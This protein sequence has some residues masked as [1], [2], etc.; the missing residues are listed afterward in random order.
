M[1]AMGQKQ[2]SLIKS[3]LELRKEYLS[4]QKD[5]ERVSLIGEE[6]MSP[7]LRV[8]NKWRNANLLFRVL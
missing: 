4:S 1:R 5:I 7:V 3:I 6:Q 2:K 8:A